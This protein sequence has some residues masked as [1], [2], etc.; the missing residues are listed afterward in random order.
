MVQQGV[1]RGVSTPSRK[2]LR[3]VRWLAA[4]VHALSVNPW[5]DLAKYDTSFAAMSSHTKKTLLPLVI[6]SRTYLTSRSAKAGRQKQHK[7]M[8][9]G[10]P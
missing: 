5:E 2:T 6:G 4:V 8:P 3:L 1:V 10:K 7:P 9:N